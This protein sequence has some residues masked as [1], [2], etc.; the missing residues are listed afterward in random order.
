MNIDALIDERRGEWDRLDEL[1]RRRRLT[2][3]ETDE[4]VHLYRAASADLAD[5]KTSIGRSAAGDYLSN[6]LARARLMLTGAPDN[7]MRQVPRFFARQLPAALYRIRWDSLIVAMSFIGIVA[8][9]GWWAQQDPAYMAAMGDE[10]QLKK[11][12]EEDFVAYYSEHSEGVFT[13]MVWTNNAWIAAQAIMFGITGVYPVFVLMQN[14]VGLGTS[15]AVMNW[16]GRGDDFLL[17]ILPHGLLEMTCIF[18]AG[19]AGMRIFWAWVA[20]GT[21]TRAT[22]L[23]AEGR[24]LATVVVGL[25]I[26]L[27]LSG[28]VEGFITRQEWPHAI[29]IGIGAIALGVFLAYMLIVGR[30]AVRAGE[31]GDL[32]EY[33]AGTSRLVAG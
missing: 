11:Y 20:P 3:A 13:G 19:A 21:R 12:A 28:L 15:A 17:F 8:L 25:V 7:V 29:K 23:A 4:F 5:I 18:V 16:Y 10:A 2:G 14:A 31:T 22:A 27:G 33:E 6:I 9:V 30:R 32:T 26:A 24:A 1:A